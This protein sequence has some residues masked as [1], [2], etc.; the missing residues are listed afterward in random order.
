MCL[1]C[2]ALTASIKFKATVEKKEEDKKKLITR[3]D[4]SPLQLITRNFKG[5]GKRKDQGINLGN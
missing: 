1:S 2:I 5:R 4:P 3:K